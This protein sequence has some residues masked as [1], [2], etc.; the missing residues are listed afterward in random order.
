LFHGLMGDR[1]A[2]ET[3][4][5]ALGVSAEL[6]ERLIKKAPVILKSGLGP[7]EARRYADA[8]QAAGGRVTIQ[9]Q[10]GL[11]EPARSDPNFSIPSFENFTMCPECGLK[12]QKGR[13]CV[14]CGYHF[15][16]F[17]EGQRSGDDEPGH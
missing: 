12:Q 11:S 6:V 9:E 3:G 2:F 13:A 15:K 5:S 10:E 8:V 14:R 4:M 17:E 16:E 7:G 1:E